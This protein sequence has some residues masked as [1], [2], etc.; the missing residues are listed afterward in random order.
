[1]ERGASGQL[2]LVIRVAIDIIVPL[3]RPG[4]SR[5]RQEG[6]STDGAVSAVI[7]ILRRPAPGRDTRPWNCADPGVVTKFVRRVTPRP[8][9]FLRDN[10]YWRYTEVDRVGRPARC[11]TGYERDRRGNRGFARLGKSLRSG[12]ERV[13]KII[14]YTTNGCCGVLRPSPRPARFHGRGFHALIDLSVPL[15]F[16]PASSSAAFPRL[17]GRLSSGR[18]VTMPVLLSPMECGLAGQSTPVL[19]IS[20]TGWVAGGTEFTVE[21]G[22]GI[23]ESCG[24]AAAVPARNLLHDPV[25]AGPAALGVLL[26]VP[27]VEESNG[28]CSLCSPDHASYALLPLFPFHTPRGWSFPSMDLPATLTVFRRFTMMVLDIGDIRSSIFPSGTSP[29]PSPRLDRGR[30]RSSCCCSHVAIN[31]RLD[32]P[33]TTSSVRPASTR[34][35]GASR[36]EGDR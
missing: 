1:V 35:D 27:A 14:S 32:G 22:R 2:I 33:L 10:M 19:R 7:S 15:I 16:V 28:F 26:L 11:T 23:I 12:S 24:A 30:S 17:L 13:P 21:F 36:G 20:S 31:H 8:D 29:S 34:S 3:P 25:G 18:L 4:V 6:L 9:H 5:Q